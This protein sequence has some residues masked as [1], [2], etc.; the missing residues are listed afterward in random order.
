MTSWLLTIGGVTQS[1]AAW[2]ITNA[3]LQFNNL[4]A[5]TLTFSAPRAQFTEAELCDYLAEVTLI[6]D[7]DGIQTTVFLGQ[8]Q[9]IA[10]DAS[11][12]SEDQAYS[13]IGPWR[14]LQENI[15]QQLWGGSLYT[16]HIILNGTIGDNIRLVLDYAIAN[17]A[18]FQY[19]LAEL[20]ALDT[21][22]FPNETTG[23]LA[24]SII[25]SSLQFAPDTVGWFD[26]TTSPP[27]LHFKQRSSLTAK[28]LRLASYLADTSLPKVKIRG[29][30]SRPDL[31][32]PS[33]KINAETINTINGV[34]TLVPSVDIYPPGATGRED[35][36]V[37]DTVIL[38]G[39]TRQNITGQI[40]TQNIT[41]DGSVAGVEYFKKHVHTLRDPRITIT[42]GPFEIERVDADG[43]ALAVTYPRE[44]IDGTIAPWMNVDF[45]REVIRM[46][47]SYVT[48]DDNDGI[49]VLDARHERTFTFEIVTTNAPLGTSDYSAL[50]SID[51]GDSSIT[52]LAQAL[53]ESMHPLHWEGVFDIEE[54]EASGYAGLGNVINLLGADADR[55]SMNALVQQVSINI[56]SGITSLQCGPPRHLTLSDILSLLARFRTSR[57]W[58]N[59]ATQQDGS[60]TDT[61]SDVSL[62]QAAP[63]TNAIPG[64][65]LTKIFT[66]KD[67]DVAGTPSIQ[68]DGTNKQMLI[69]LGNGQRVTI[70]ASTAEWIAATNKELKIKLVDVCVNNSTKQM[71]VIGTDPW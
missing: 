44:L 46:K 14:W 55:A 58:T 68:M 9:M 54:E 28:S 8:R 45:Q 42:A 30:R 65:A 39:V 20:N 6:R 26:Y 62:G 61:G 60:I 34:Q 64:S 57:R 31:Q 37:T 70:Q 3:Q 69:N 4:A 50:E 22:P 25:L 71:L 48:T 40:T 47:L 21:T 43:N 11:A 56:D 27:T 1:L 32:V 59:P 7:V 10:I 19:V 13:F 2:R 15:Y 17:G 5:D 24:S 63:N 52:G 49:T 33:V 51:Y 23:Q 35:G 12:Q 16:S 67:P 41:L 18:N 38:R 36:A 29:L 53:Y 66:V